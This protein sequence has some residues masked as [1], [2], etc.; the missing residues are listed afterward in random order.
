MIS[1][2][3]KLTQHLH[4]LFE[5]KLHSQHSDHD[6]TLHVTRVQFYLPPKSRVHARGG[7]IESRTVYILLNNNVEMYEC[8]K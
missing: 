8:F 6:K 4:I 2:V 5:V 7:P 3:H 1:N